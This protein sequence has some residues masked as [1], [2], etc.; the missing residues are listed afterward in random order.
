MTSPNNLTATDAAKAIRAGELTSRALVDAC[1]T[2]AEA[3][4]ADVGAWTYLNPCIARDQADNCDH[5]ITAGRA[6]GPLHG[7]PVGLKDIIDTADM[8]TENGSRLYEGRRPV[9][10]IDYTRA[11]YE[12]LPDFNEDAA[13]EYPLSDDDY[14]DNENEQE[15]DDGPAES[16]GTGSPLP[17]GPAEAC[18]IHWIHLCHL[19]CSPQ[20]SLR[21]PLPDGPAS[22]GIHWLHCLHPHPR[23]RNHP[24]RT[25]PQ[26]PH[27]HLPWT[28]PCHP[29]S[30]HPAGT[31]A[32]VASPAAAVASSSRLFPP[33]SSTPGRRTVRTRSRRWPQALKNFHW[34]GRSRGLIGFQGWGVR[35]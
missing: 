6:P 5:A 11:E 10:V 3:R 33:G 25:Q 9:A 20:G 21:D 22:G 12:A 14:G 19:C 7:I 18:G 27:P 15:L 32:T 24:C 4:D 16:G 29:P 26:I 30:P 34:T 17:D 8:P 23:C 1:I 13:S 28:S 35:G 31:L 2:R